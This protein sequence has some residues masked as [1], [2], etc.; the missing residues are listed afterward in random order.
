MNVPAAAPA[1]TAPIVVTL[2]LLLEGDRG[3]THQWNLLIDSFRSNP[4]ALWWSVTLAYSSQVR[5]YI[6]PNCEVDNILSQSFSYTCYNSLMSEMRVVLA[7]P[8]MTMIRHWLIKKWVQNPIC[9]GGKHFFC[10]KRIPCLQEIF[11]DYYWEFISRD[12][13]C[14]SNTSNFMKNCHCKYQQ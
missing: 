10:A 6:P 2:L 11:N 4:S 8:V 12:L 14:L 1:M 13:G 3:N 5:Q 7:F 9:F